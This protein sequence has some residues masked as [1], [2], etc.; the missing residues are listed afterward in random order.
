MKNILDYQKR[1]ELLHQH[2]KER[3]S[4]ICDRIKAVLWFD[5]GWT[6]EE[7]TQALFIDQSTVRRHLKDTLE[8]ESVKPHHKGSQPILNVFQSQIL[9][10]HLQDNVYTRTQDIVHFIKN[11][12]DQKI[13]VSAVY[14]WLQ[15]H[16]FSY[17]KPKTIPKN[18]DPLEQAEFIQEY[19][20]LMNS[21][22]LEGEIV[23]FGDSVHPSQQTRLGYGW[24]HKKTAKP[25]ET[26]AGRKR[27]NLMGA[28][29][30]ED[31]DVFYETYETINGAN[32]IDFLKKLEKRYKMIPK[33]HLILDQAGY[34]TCK[35]VKEYL[36]NSKI[37]VHFL[38]PRSPNLNPIE[39]LWKVMHAYVSNNKCYAQF[40]DFKKALLYFFDSTIAKI[41]DEL[42]SSVTD[43]FR[44][45][46]S[47]SL[48]K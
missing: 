3:D 33:I 48:A 17:K 41:K 46:G 36:K 14:S 42:V 44:V 4:R 18:A 19:E 38:P 35:E 11:K 39:R 1:A 29:E 20:K 16:G 22:A 45:V 43:N 28:I 27:I 31:M 40:R 7:I 26:T 13:S 10:E 34:H 15:A 24:Y 2:K 32:C 47:V 37:Q 5:D 6:L 9:I 23:L 12:W 8:N 30:L 21:A 25:L